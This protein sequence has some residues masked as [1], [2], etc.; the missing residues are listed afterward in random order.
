MGKRS[1]FKYQAANKYGVT[2]AV[3]SDTSLTE[4]QILQDGYQFIEISG[5]AKLTLPAASNALWGCIIRVF[6]SGQGFVFVS[7]GFG[8]R[9]ASFDTVQNSQAETTDFWCGKGSDGNYYW[10]ALTPNVGGAGSSS[11]SSS[12]SS[13]MSSSSSSSS[14]MSSSSSSMS[15]SS[16]SNSSSS[17]SSS[18]G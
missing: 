11:S 12:S 8:G 2:L 14:S 3:T 5:Y 16:S 9:G 17:S 7:G 6:T 15:S 4:A 1:R 10:Y 13:S 18:S